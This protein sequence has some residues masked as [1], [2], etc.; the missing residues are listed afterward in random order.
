MLYH[1]SIAPHSIRSS[2]HSSYRY[3]VRKG[4][5]EFAYRGRRRNCRPRYED[6]AVAAAILASAHYR[7]C[8]R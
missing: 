3:E 5:D 4:Y 8:N 2:S 7:T 6:R 1:R